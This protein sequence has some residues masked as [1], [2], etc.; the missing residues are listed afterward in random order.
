MD[1]RVGP[2]G[3]IITGSVFDCNR[4]SLERSLKFFDPQL[5]LKWNPRKRAGHGIWELRRRPTF[6]TKILQGHID[7]VPLYTY[8]YRE[9]DMIH[10]ILD[11]PVLRYD[12]LGRVKE[13]DSWNKKN[14][15]DNLDEQGAKAIMDAKAKAKAELRYSIKQHKREWKDFAA[16]VSAGGNPMPWLKGTW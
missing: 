14:Y 15:L 1:N 9:N 13:M 7:G 3:N 6:K 5:Y 2:L 4:D 16:F 11:V 8:E 12:L 10:H